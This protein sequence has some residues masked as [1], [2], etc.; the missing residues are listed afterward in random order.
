VLTPA[1]SNHRS[2]ISGGEGLLTVAA[3]SFRSI[4]IASD[5]L[6]GFVLEA[7]ARCQSLQL[8][9]GSEESQQKSKVMKSKTNVKA[10][11][12]VKFR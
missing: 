4:Q 3:G 6:H 9:H 11:T 2:S 7:G 1:Y 8:L 5:W 12:V 10:G